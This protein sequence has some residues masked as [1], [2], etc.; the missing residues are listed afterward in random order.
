MAM[1]KYSMTPLFMVTSKIR[2]WHITVY[3]DSLNTCFNQFSLKIQRQ[4][5]LSSCI[6]HQWHSYLS[7]N[8][9]L[10]EVTGAAGTVPRSAPRSAPRFSSLK[11]FQFLSGLTSMRV[12]KKIIQGLGVYQNREAI[13]FSIAI[14]ILTF[15]CVP[16]PRY[17]I[18]NVWAD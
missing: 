5:F 12:M 16:E 17:F 7:F 2:I 13:S 15:I 8:I 1:W 6:W 10:T 3:R 18:Q 9:S 4:R 14:L 11:H